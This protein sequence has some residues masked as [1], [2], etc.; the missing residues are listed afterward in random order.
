M[1]TVNYT[2]DVISGVIS[3]VLF[4]LSAIGLH[5]MANRQGVKRPWLAFIPILQWYTM[6]EIVK[7]RKFIKSGKR[8]FL[9]T[10]TIFILAIIIIVLS[11]TLGG[12]SHP[13]TLLLIVIGILM[14]LYIGITIWVLHYF[15]LAQY[16][17]HATILFLLGILIAPVIMYLAIFFIRNNPPQRPSN[18]PQEAEIEQEQG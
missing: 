2:L 7:D 15:I 17:K 14:M 6:A 4:I 16:T 1:D 3:F 11:A 18:P 10:I 5:T 13:L 9:K 8:F 12:G